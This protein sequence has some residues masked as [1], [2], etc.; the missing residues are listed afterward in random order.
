MCN[1][2]TI[3]I[4]GLS[5]LLFVSSCKD[6]PQVIEQIRSIKTITVKETATGKIR[7]FSG[8]VQ[9]TE[10]S[11]LSF[12]VG[13]MVQ[14]VHVDIGDHVEKG[15]ELA[16]LDDEP[17]KLEVDAAKAE[18]DKA[19][20]SV[21][22]TKAEYERQKRVYEQGAGT[23]NKLDQSKYDYDA[24]QSSVVFHVSQMKL[25]ERNRRKTSMKAPYEGHIAARYVEP[26]EEIQPGRQV[27]DLDAVGALEV[28]LAIPET[29]ISQIQTGTAATVTFPI[30]PGQSVTGNIT[31]IGSAAIKANAFPVKI[32]LINPPASIIPGTTAEAS[33][34]LLVEGQ[35]TGF[36]IPLQSLLPSEKSGH[37]YV[38]VYDPAA[39]IVKKTPVRISS[40]GSEKNMMVIEEGLAPGDIIATAGVTFLVDGMKVKLLEK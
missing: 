31:E 23:K 36:L 18:L 6:K 16:V 21:V 14:S 8:I 33:L 35:S 37:G 3:I 26:H 12:E 11:R 20:A 1:R 24:A 9:A 30:L 10:T 5:I 25:A 17:Y 4:A 32:A 38:F 15:Q 2:L 19:K 28:V 22:N 27:F 7:K 34:L 13:G 29:T 39:S 40:H